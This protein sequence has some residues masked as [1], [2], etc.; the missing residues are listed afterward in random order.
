MK[1][2]KTTIPMFDKLF[3]RYCE[4]LINYVR[5]NCPEPVMTVNNNLAC[6]FF[7]LMDCYMFP[8]FDTELKKVSAEEVEDLEQMLEGFF[9]F[10]S[11]WTIGAT[12]NLDGRAKFNIKI[13]DIMGKDNKFKFPNQGTCYDYKFDREKKEWIYWT[14]T[15]AD[16]AIDPKA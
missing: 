12:T 10:C 15:I 6:S 9:I 2:R 4:P 11:I 3:E 14:D 8:Y 5:K 7:R 1:L 13:R 16:F